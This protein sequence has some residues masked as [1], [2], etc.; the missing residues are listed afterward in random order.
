MFSLFLTQSF[1]EPLNTSVYL[2]LTGAVEKYGN[3]PAMGWLDVVAK[4]GGWAKAR[5]IFFLPRLWHIPEISP[6]GV[7][8]YGFKLVNASTVS[9]AR[10]AA[11]IGGNW[12]GFHIFWNGTSIKSLVQAIKNITWIKTTGNLTITDAYTVFAVSLEGFE[13]ITG[14]VVHSRLI[15]ITTDDIPEGDLNYDGVVD[16]RD[17]AQSAKAYGAI[18]G[19][20]RYDLQADINFDFFVDI[21][22]IGRVCRNFGKSY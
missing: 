8:I 19:E 21:R 13:L 4:D 22:D 1:A 2:Q 18:V 16:I 10:S 9:V 17:I 15:A 6:I 20:I 5:V 3:D 7:H 12:T 14:K 11:F